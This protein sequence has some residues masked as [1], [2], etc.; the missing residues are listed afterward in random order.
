MTI[1][2]AAS[3][4]APRR[5]V[6][7]GGCRG[8][9]YRHPRAQLGA[10]LAAPAGLARHRLPRVAAPALR[11][12][13]F[14]SARLVHRQPRHRADA[15]QNFVEI[16]TDARSTARSR[17][18]RSSWR[19]LVT[20]TD[21]RPRLPDR[22]LHGARRVAPDA[23]APGRLDPAAAV[24]R[25][26]RQGLR[27]AADPQRGRRP[28]LGPR[29]ARA[30]RARA[31]ATSPS[32][33]SM[34]Y[35]WLPYMILPIY[36]GLERIP[37]SLLEASGDLGGR[38]GT[39]FR[40]V[41]LPLALPAVVAGSIFTFSLTLGDYIT[42]TLVSNTQFIGNVIYSTSWASRQP[43]ARGRL[44]DGPG[45]DHARVPARRPPPRRVRGA[46][47]ELGRGT[48][49]ALRIATA[50]ILAFIYLPIVVIVLY[51]FNASRV[52]TLADQRADPR[53]VPARRSPTRASG[54]RSWP[55]SR[56]RSAPRPSRWSLGTL[57]ALRRPALPVL[58]PRGALV[59]R[60]P[61]A[62]PAGH[63]DRHRAEHR[64]P[65]DRH[66]ARAVHDHRRPRDVLRR[67]R[68]QQRRSPGCGGPSA[69]VEEASMDLGADTFQ[70]FRRITLPGD[71]DG[72][73][74]RRAAGLRPVVRRDHR[75]DLHGRCGH[76]DAA[77]L[78]L[79]RTTSA[80]TS[81]RS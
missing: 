81:C 78:D 15:S 80:R 1:R 39:T 56:R 34:S 10:L 17:S 19:P 12:S 38:A 29:A 4:T 46:L 74:R 47:M 30:A 28:E 72:A 8:A 67:R 37:D 45:R 36:A 41:V 64:L 27:L 49:I 60:R 32:G 75:H 69:T 2:R 50:A 42:P 61:A 40:R 66:R 51:S 13:A 3:S 71:P 16:L 65:D 73:A 70:T 48:R 68:L 7:C 25:L 63:R 53:L 62:R 9:L 14:W 77:D 26:P 5:I 44:R 20:L 59:P 76:P 35:L 52:A 79:Q 18:G 23:R 43:A 11:V 24:V 58:R 33:S 21:D 31:T 6:R 55:R 57:I 22:V 54:A